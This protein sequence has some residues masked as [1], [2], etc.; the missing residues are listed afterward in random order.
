MTDL[1]ALY[2]AVLDRPDDDTPRL[3]CADALDDLMT[4]EAMARAEFIRVQC[5]LARLPDEPFV[6]VAEA[7]LA[8]RLPRMSR[9]ERNESRDILLPQCFPEARA[10][11]ADRD[12]KRKELRR[13]E[14]DLF[15]SSG[16]AGWWANVPG[17]WR[18][19]GDDMEIHATEGWRFVVRRGFVD[20]VRLPLAALVGGVCDNCGGTGLVDGDRYEQSEPC[21]DC[22]GEYGPSD[23]DNPRGVCPGTGRTPG[24]AADLF[25][26]H[27]VTAVR[28][29]DVEP[30]V[31]LADPD[32][33]ESHAWWRASSWAGRRWEPGAEGNDLGNLPDEVFDAM[34][35]L[36]PERVMIAG[37]PPINQHIAFPTRDE[38]Y[39]AL[40]T[41][42]VAHGR[43]LAGLR[44]IV[45]AD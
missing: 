19:T 39:A 44:A 42:A 28:I 41:A 8:E 11:V 38:A 14:R 12:A 9:L 30:W 24:I 36:C 5:E 43:R 33:P 25:R 17:N 23:E 7:V 26:S 45:P 18:S 16:P 27:P 31:D 32:G 4:P 13:R 35:A 22:G 34:A 10:R 40:S 2:A 6:R 29:S 21:P 15:Q 20:E 3:V 1:D 37:G